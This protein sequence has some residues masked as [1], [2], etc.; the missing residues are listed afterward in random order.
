MKR[1]AVRRRPTGVTIG[2]LMFVSVV[3]ALV[4]RIVRTDSMTTRGERIVLIAFAI[5]VVARILILIYYARQCPACGKGPVGLVA[6]V[7]LGDH[8]FRCDACGQRLKRAWLGR[9]WDASGPEDDRRFVKN[10]PAP[11]WPEGSFAPSVDQP[12]TRTVGMLLRGKIEREALA[13]DPVE[14]APGEIGWTG[15]SCGDTEH[16]PANRSARTGVQHP[17]ATAFFRTLDAIR[18]ARNSRR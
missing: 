6:A 18:W 13:P 14:I 17:V 15:E 1:A 7:P 9:V 5:V 16:F 12:A 11:D 10:R 2:R 4:L 3:V 8:F